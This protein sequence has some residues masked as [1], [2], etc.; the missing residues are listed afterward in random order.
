MEIYNDYRGSLT[1]LK[2]IPYEV[3]EILISKNIPNV[4]RGLH[5]SPYRKRVYVL[6]GEIYDFYIDP[7]TKNKKEII[8]K[9]GEYVDIPAN[10]AHGF[11][12][13]NHSEIIYLLEGKFDPSIDKLIYWNDIDLGLYLNFNKTNLIIS[14]KDK[15]ALYFKKYDYIILGANGFLGSYCVKILKEQGYTVFESNERF[16]NISFIEEQILKSQAKYLICA[17]GISGKPTIDW[18]EHNEEE[19]YKINYLAI[20][21]LMRLTNKLNIHCTIFGSGLIYNGNK[22]KYSENDKPDY[23]NKVYSKW[24]IELEK[25]IHFYKNILYLRIIYPASLDNNPKCFLTK[26][27]GRSKNVHNINISMTII[28][29][30]F[31]KIKDLCESNITGIF[32]FVNKGSISLPELLLLYSKYKMYLDINI[33]SNCDSRGAYEL[34]T[35]KLNNIIDNEKINE[36]I[37]LYLSTPS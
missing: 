12:S 10:W 27:I 16:N 18:C 15:N 33:N 21:D 22:E 32:N 4:L 8:I 13:Y 30:L 17:A 20:I 28:P 35:D 26:M 3:K 11:Y 29:S 24:R 6:K 37:V 2:E 23:I 34:L 9:Q 14:D 7:Y 31:P 1:S 36:A 5:M 19:T 25:H